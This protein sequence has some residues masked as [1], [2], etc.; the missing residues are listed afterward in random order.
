V[1]CDLLLTHHLSSTH[2]SAL[3]Y[4]IEPTASPLFTFTYSLSGL[5][6]RLIKKLSL[7]V[8][9]TL[10]HV[11]SHTDYLFQIFSLL[12]FLG[13]LI[14]LELLLWLHIDDIAFLIYHTSLSIHKHFSGG[15]LLLVHY[16]LNKIL[17]ILIE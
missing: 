11:L 4:K 5:F 15:P 13:V 9:F 16:L 7:S 12:F 1:L 10:G 8:L 6:K 3:F 14:D 2:I 17:I